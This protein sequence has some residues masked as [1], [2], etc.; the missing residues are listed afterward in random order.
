[1]SRGVAYW[2]EGRGVGEGTEEVDGSAAELY[3]YKCTRD[4]DAIERGV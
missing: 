4:G 1:M 2:G 3:W